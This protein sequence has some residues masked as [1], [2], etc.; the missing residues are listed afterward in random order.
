MVS[1][2]DSQSYFVHTEAF[3]IRITPKHVK[4]FDSAHCRQQGRFSKLRAQDS[5]S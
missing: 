3:M 5:A 2:Q 4:R 1:L